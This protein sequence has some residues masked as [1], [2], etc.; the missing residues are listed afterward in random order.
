M[1]HSV[2]LFESGSACSEPQMAD[3]FENIGCL[4]LNKK[5]KKAKTIHL[6]LHADLIKNHKKN[7][8]A[9]TID[10]YLHAALIKRAKTIDQQL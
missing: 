5:N 10:L 7:K 8:K 3:H 4:N 1:G 6:H 9:K 2:R